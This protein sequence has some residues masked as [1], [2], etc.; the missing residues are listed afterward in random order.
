[1]PDIHRWK[2]FRAGGFDQVKLETGEDFAH[3]ED[4]DQKLWV[5]LAC[6]AEGLYFDRRTIQLIDSDKDGR[7]R[8]PELLAAVKFACAHLKEPGDLLKGKGTLSLSAISDA[9]V[10][11]KTLRAAARRI[12]DNTGKSGATEIGV[13]DL[14]DPVKIFAN[15]PFNGDGI[16][17]EL[18]AGSDPGA[19][20]AIKDVVEC[21]GGEPDRAGIQGIG[22]ASIDAFFTELDLYAAWHARAE[23]P[24]GAA[25][26]LP[27]GEDG[28]TAALAAIEQIRA[29]VD[30]YFGRCRLAAFDPRTVTLLNRQEEEYLTIASQDLSITADE[31]AAFP[32]AQ[33]AAGRPLILTGA[34]N[35]AHATA[36]E[37]LRRDAIGPLLGDRQ[38]L[39]EPDWA[40]LR[41][42]VAPFETWKAEMPVLRVTKLGAARIG[43]LRRSG[44]PATL[45]DLV[46]ADKAIEAEA[47]GIEDVERLVRYHRDL[48]LL[49]SNFVNFRDFYDGKDPAIFQVGTLYLDQR[50]CGLCLPVDDATK[51]ATLAGLAGAYLAYLDCTRKATGEKRQIVAAFTSGDSDNLMIGRNGVFYDREGRDWDATIAKIIDNPISV[52]QAFWSPYK[53]FARFIEEQVAKRAAAADAKS[54][55]VLSTTA[56]TAVNLDSAKPPEPKKVDVGTVAALGVAVGAVG[57]FVTGLIGYATGLFRLGVLPTVAAFVGVILLISLPSVV[58]AYMK[59][60]RRNLGPILDANGWAV[61]AKAKIS[62]PFGTTLTGVARLPPG[63]RRDSSDKFADKGVPWK[64]VVFVLLVG[65][66][67]YHWYV[68]SFDRFL[69]EPARAQT[70]LGDWFPRP[71]A[72]TAAPAAAAPTP[73]KM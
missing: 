24:E 2:F 11:S 53:K 73:G 60:R 47:T 50:S 64:R 27:L 28:M 26:I 41:A 71:A 17:T 65:Y 5:A 72:P 57:A 18:S 25:A 14:A 10:A 59:L 13:E 62:V 4:L 66:L 21:L 16:I 36:I 35:P 12:L 52:R 23:T 34:I 44:L 15:T 68:G 31:V 7:I 42:R 61:N 30:D 37:A 38:E 45:T 55:N 63:A 49:C 51:H 6:P 33:V 69:P 8:A 54:H 32:L 39:G 48:A 19:R 9:T 56:T 22:Q 3:L 20:A 40:R 46:L 1:M 43:E 67:A 70:V 58:L 29:K